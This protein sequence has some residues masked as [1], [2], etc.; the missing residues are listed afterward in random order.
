MGCA[1][2]IRRT[3]EQTND[4]PGYT[5][6]LLLHIRLS[7]LN[8]TAPAGDYYLHI[9]VSLIH[10]I[11]HAHVLWTSRSISI[12]KNVPQSHMNCMKEQ[13]TL[14]ATLVNST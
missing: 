4:A 8:N 12:L 1:L 14:Q 10:I 7:H 9:I 5:A 6:A 11:C 13:T 3:V 2:L